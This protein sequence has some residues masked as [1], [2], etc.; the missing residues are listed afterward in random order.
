[1]R[2]HQTIV[3][4]KHRADLPTSRRGGTESAEPRLTKND[5]GLRVARGTALGA[6]AGRSGTEEGWEVH[7]KDVDDSWE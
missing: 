6:P 1:V 5:V 4:V 7:E 3:Q 2:V